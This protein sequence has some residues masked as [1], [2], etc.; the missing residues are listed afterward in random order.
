MEGVCG[1]ATVLGGV[2]QRVDHLV[3]LDD[4]PRPA[5]SDDQRHRLW[6]WALAVDEVDGETVNSGLELREA[7]E[8]SL[9][10]APVV[11]VQPVVA[12][13]ASVGEG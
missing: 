6:M 4:G 8:V 12:D 11:V 3:K 1:I 9:P 2:Y 7:V 10:G 13:L 5:V